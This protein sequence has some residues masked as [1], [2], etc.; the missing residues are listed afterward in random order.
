[1]MRRIFL[2]LIYDMHHLIFDRPINQIIRK[3]IKRYKN[4]KTT[5]NT[6]NTIEK[7]R[8]DIILS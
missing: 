1:M 2:F 3:V 5:Q 8:N 4:S 6:V 7:L